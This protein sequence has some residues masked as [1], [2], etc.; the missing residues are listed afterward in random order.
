[1]EDAARGI[2]S[3]TAFYDGEAPVNIGSGQEISM[4]DLAA[5]IAD[6][7]GYAGRIVWDEGQPN[8]QPRRMLD[9]SRAARE[10]GFCARVSLDEGLRTTIDFYRE[11]VG[12]ARA[13]SQAV[14]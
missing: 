2:I 7:T 9:V 1:V 11:T 4:R 5:K 6:F 12:G 10:F 13:Y 3:A 8:G 14:Q